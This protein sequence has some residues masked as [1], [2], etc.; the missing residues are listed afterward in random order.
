MGRKIVLFSDL[1]AHPF[2]PYATILENGMNSRLADAVSCVEQIV[3]YCN[4]DP[5]VEAVAFAGDMFHV[6][7]TINVPAFNAIYEALARFR[8][9]GVPLV[10][11][12][13][14]HDQADRLG[15]S[16]AIYA[17]RTFATVLDRPGWEILQGRSGY[18][19]TLLGVPYMED[20]QS[21]REVVDTPAP[22]TGLPRLFLGHLGIQG[23]RV[24]A[25]FV[26]TNP[27]DAA[28]HDL[29]QDAFDAGFL[30]H[31]HIH[32]AVG[33]RF[34]YIGA[35]LQH[36][37]GDAHQWRGFLTYDMDRGT[38]EH[39]DLVAPRFLRV[40][41]AH[42]ST[43]SQAQAQALL[44]DSY[45]RVTDRRTWTDDEREAWRQM[46][47]ARSVEVVNE[48]QH[49][50]EQQGPRIEVGPGMSPQD[51]LATYVRSGIQPHDDLD[52]DYLL[53]LGL[54]VM[55]EVES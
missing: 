4:E 23:A 14:N 50:P 47:G 20:V 21:L 45:V 40:E 43:L 13:G 44:R 12:H 18:P 33:P 52:E 2:K 51:L 53:Q 38:I 55:E 25:D 26:Y 39:H 35:P 32:Q 27:H 48:V 30:G 19:F 7:R 15:E 46:T 22:A 42:L 54:D 41:A 17:F 36:N 11:I 6:R 31:Y 5:E 24:G 10:M 3:A 8:T 16:H 9:I 34:W 28:A 49:K 1:H 29:N 37:W